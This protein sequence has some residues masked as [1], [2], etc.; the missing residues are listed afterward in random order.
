[1]LFPGMDDTQWTRKFKKVQSKK[2]VKSNK[3]I[4]RNFF[5]QK[6]NFSQ[7]QKWPKNNIWTGKKFKSAKNAISRKKIDLF[8]FTSFFGLDFSK[9]SGPLQDC[10]S[11]NYFEILDRL[12]RS[13]W[14]I[15]LLKKA[16]FGSCLNEFINRSAKTWKKWSQ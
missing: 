7:F 3:S 12:S 2:I 9:F 14:S 13:S 10:V 1:M 6:F 5:D 11:T 16:V 15:K 4:S 8:N